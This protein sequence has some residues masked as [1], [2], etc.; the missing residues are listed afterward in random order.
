M[1]YP[2]SPKVSIYL[3]FEL[4]Y[5]VNRQ[6][7]LLFYY[8]QQRNQTKLDLFCFQRFSNNFGCRFG[9][10]FGNRFGGPEGADSFSN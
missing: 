10:R 5:W 2:E 4:K 7:A 6:I 3:V 1:H 9:F 8:K